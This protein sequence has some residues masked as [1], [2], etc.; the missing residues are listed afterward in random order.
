MS[1][2]T[3]NYLPLNNENKYIIIKISRNNVVSSINTFNLQD[4]LQKLKSF[5]KTAEISTVINNTNLII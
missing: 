4:D 1:I 2:L 5:I 3:I